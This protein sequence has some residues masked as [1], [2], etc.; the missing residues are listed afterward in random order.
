MYKRTDLEQVIARRMIKDGQP[1]AL[2]KKKASA[3]VDFQIRTG[4]CRQEGDAIILTSQGTTE[5][6]DHRQRSR[7]QEN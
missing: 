3:L 4:S 6:Q 2:A 7:A 1:E 5:V